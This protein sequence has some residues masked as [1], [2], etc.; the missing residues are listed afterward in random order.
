MTREEVRARVQEI[1]IIPAVRVASAEDAV[2]AAESV[3]HG[4]IGVVELTMTTPGAFEV[5]AK[6]ARTTPNL[7]VGA[8]TVLDLDTARRC[9]DA[10]VAFLT[11]PSLDLAIVEFGCKQNVLVIPGALTPTEV[12]NAGRAGADLI[13]I[14]PCSQV[15]GPGYIRALRAPFAHLSLIASGGVLPQ[16]A[17]EYIRAGAVALGIGT[18]LIPPD[19]V[20][21]KN[22]R[23]IRELCIRFLGVVREG[24]ALL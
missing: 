13:K 6:L 22:Q 21:A 2:F 19:A 23:W 14:F 7:I 16:S 12:A 20:L 9:L 1:G 17:V 8:G 15:G 10:G 5:I 24:R 18:Y 3:F 4:G 11:S